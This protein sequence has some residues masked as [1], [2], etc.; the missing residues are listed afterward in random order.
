MALRDSAAHALVLQVRVAVVE[1]EG[2]PR[3]LVAFGSSRN[4]LVAKTR[5]RVVVK[6]VEDIELPRLSRA[7]SAAA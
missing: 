1:G 3:S 2:H 6:H 7:L 5:D 4:R